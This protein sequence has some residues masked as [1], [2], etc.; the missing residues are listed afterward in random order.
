V[1]SGT[2]AL[3]LALTAV[4]V[5]AGDEVITVSHSF[6]ATANAI[7]LCGAKPVFVDIERETLNLDPS[8]VERAI[9]PRTKALLC[10]HQLGMPCDLVRLNEIA[11]RR[12][13]A[14]VED[15]ACAIGSEIRI[16]E[17]WEKIG[18]PHSRVACF[19]FHPRK[20]LTTGEG[21]MVTTAD[22][23]LDAK[24]RRLRQ[25]GDF[26]EVGW[27]FRLTDM[28]AAIGRV[29]L[30]RLPS[31]LAERRA[32]VGVYRAKLIAVRVPAEPTFARSNWQSLCVQLPDG[33]D[34][35]RVA[36]KMLGEGIVTRPG[37]PNAH[38]RPFYAASQQLPVSESAAERGLMLPLHPG[39]SA[40]DIDR[41]CQAL[42][43]SL[44]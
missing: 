5:G 15:A 36:A 11:A 1:S 17:T 21:G 10:V 18:K 25:H 7:T 28:Q 14:L 19:S 43:S 27:N 44:S 39:L 6:I 40:E 42:S 26:V 41:V 20:L 2:A 16:A 33:I 34:A 9:G 30:G 12:G 31:L 4:G 3:Q 29:Q 24:V 13:V 23:Q 32:Q 37:I 35:A 38:Q 22:A 8:L